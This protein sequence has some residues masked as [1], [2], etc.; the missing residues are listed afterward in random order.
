MKKLLVSSL[1]CMGMIASA[2]TVFNGGDLDTAGNWSAGLPS[3][4]TGTVAVDGVFDTSVTGR[5]WNVN[6]TG[7]TITAS[8]TAPV[9]FD[10]GSWVMSNSVWNFNDFDFTN[11][12]LT[13]GAGSSFTTSTIISLQSSSLIV[14]TGGLYQG[15]N[16]KDHNHAFNSSTIITAN[17]GTIAGLNKTSAFSGTLNLNGGSIQFNRM[18]DGMTGQVNIGTSGTFTVGAFGNI[19]SGIMDWTPNSAASV[20]IGQT[21]WAETWWD[22]GSLLYNGQNNTDLGLTWSQASSGATQIWDFSGNTL[23]VVAIPEPSS[24]AL[25]GIALAGLLVW[26]R[27]K[28]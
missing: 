20:T 28:V 9:D 11:F 24:L 13:I 14:E 26:R 5:N 8:S 19:G 10:G 4:G 6:Q 7:G 18:R 1:C 21:G 15:S 16:N 17:G 22:A 23:T 2:Q 3:S 25:M 12:N 27:R